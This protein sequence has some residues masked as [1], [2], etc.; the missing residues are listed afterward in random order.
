MLVHIQ[1]ELQPACH[2]L[3]FMSKQTSILADLGPLQPEGF[4]GGI[5]QLLRLLLPK[6]KDL[7]GDSIALTVACSPKLLGAIEAKDLAT[8]GELRDS[9][10]ISQSGGQD[11]DVLY[12]PFGFSPFFERAKASVALIV[13][14]LHRDLPW[15]LPKQV[16]NHRE[17]WMPQVCER[18]DLL[19]CSS[20]FVVK[21]LGLHFGVPASKCFIVRSAIQQR[22][23]RRGLLSLAK[24]PRAFLYPAN[25]WPHKNH[26]TLLV[27]YRHY[28][29]AE[30]ST[31]WRLILTGAQDPRGEELS[32]LASNLG[33]DDHIDWLGHV[34][35]A[36]YQQVWDKTG[37]LVFPSLYEGYGIP[38]V[39]AMQVGVPVICGSHGSLSEVGGCAVLRTDTR[40]P[41]R[42]SAALQ[43][44]SSSRQLRLK[45][46]LLGFLRVRGLLLEREARILLRSLM[47]V[48]R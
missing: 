27:A 30:G 26:E 37:A 11:W 33:L 39:E 38:L 9:N 2:G 19:Q 40:S 10:S 41:F 1:P 20:G 25:F 29:R 23:R 18:A 48:T 16:V 46:I 34:P 13:D 14:T 31:R 15:C 7:A 35:D 22:L 24:A 6:V 17:S 32:S 42:I 45:C 21:Q 43:A 36:S 8:C 3:E 4:N 44:I 28:L 12:A 5:G 47:K